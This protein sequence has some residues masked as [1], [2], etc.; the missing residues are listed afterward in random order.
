MRALRAIALVANRPSPVAERPTRTG[1][2]GILSRLE[3]DPEKG[4][5]AFRNDHAR[6]KSWDV[7]RFDLKRMTLQT[8]TKPGGSL[9]RAVQLRLAALDQCAMRDEPA[10]EPTHGPGNRNEKDGGEDHD[11]CAPQIAP[12]A[13]GKDQFPR[14]AFHMPAHPARPGGGDPGPAD[15]REHRHDPQQ[16]PAEQRPISAGESELRLLAVPYDIGEKPAGDQ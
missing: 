6:R 3:H 1:R 2:A 10:R 14:R 13:P 12:A 7:N 4:K 16:G 11:Q 15:D 9:R 8:M 5:P